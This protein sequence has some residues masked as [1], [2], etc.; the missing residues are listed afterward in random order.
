L[1]PHYILILPDEDTMAARKLAY[2]LP[3]LTE[4]ALD[5]TQR[6]L[7][8]SMR[9]GPRGGRVNLR[10]PFGVYMLAPQYGELT[11]QL[12][13]Y[14]RF[15]T[16]VPPRLSEFA[17][18]CI[19]RIWRAQYEWH[20]HAPIAEQAGVKPQTIRDIRAGRAPKTAPADERAIWDFVQ[21]LF[22]RRRVSERNY[23]RL[24]KLLGMR[25]I[26]ELTGILGYYTSV[27]MVLNVFNVPLPD[28][29]EPYFAE[30]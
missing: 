16:C 8:Q 5:E 3:V 4:E 11:Q 7:L 2:R 15:N 13:A 14:L 21:E 28:G 25:G 10:G 27:S 30:P 1:Q 24:H 19:S 26:I 20:A 29:A 18:L 17:I 12:G 23:K 22:K 9:T 6:A